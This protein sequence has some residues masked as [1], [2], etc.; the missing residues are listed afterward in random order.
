MANT[1]FY[2][3]AWLPVLACFALLA[4]CGSKPYVDYDTGYDFAAAQTFYIIPTEVPNEPFMAQRVAAA[5]H[6][7]LTLKG[8]K[9]VNNRSDADLAITY[10]VT[11]EERANTSRVSF[12]MGTGSYGSSGGASVGTSVSKPVGGDT[13]LFNTIQIDMFPGDQ[14]TLIW[15]GSDSFE[16]KGVDA[17][18]KA[19]AAFKMVARIMTLFPPKAN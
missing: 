9:P 10:N 5:I 6:Q 4:G 1:I 16:V 3:L 11:A 13:R 12:G 14:N 8:L 7:D 19:E 2:R 17:N 15:R 18:Q